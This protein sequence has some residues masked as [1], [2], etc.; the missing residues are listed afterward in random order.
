GVPVVASL[1]DVAASGGYW[2]AA[3]CDKIVAN[4][5]TVTGSIGVF[6]AWSNWQELYQKIGIRGEIIKSGPYKDIMSDK[7]EMSPEERKIL[8]TMVDQIYG[9]FLSAVAKGRHMDMAAVKILADGRIFTGQQAVDDGLADQTGDFTAAVKLAKSLAGLPDNAPVKPYRE[10]GWLTWLSG[11]G[12]RATGL[13][14]VL[15]R[16]MGIGWPAGD[17][18]PEGV[19]PMALML[20]G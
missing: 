19:I 4:P 18:R 6:I 3:T 2:L 14:T 16:Q 10:H 17:Q 1:G 15:K 8:Q 9:Q 12:V 13:V 7:R 11:A 5:G 20:P